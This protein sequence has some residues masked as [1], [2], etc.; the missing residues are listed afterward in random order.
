MPLY[1]TICNISTFNNDTLKGST[2]T[3]A[4]YKR[5][6]SIASVSATWR[7]YKLRER[8]FEIKLK[9]LEDK[10]QTENLVHSETKDFLIKKIQSTNEETLKWERKYDQDVGALDSKI[11][12]LTT[13]RT[14]LLDKLNTLRARRQ[15]EI[16][17][18]INKTEQEMPQHAL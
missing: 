12:T 13:E 5:K 3:D 2:A 14:A 15:K 7:A 10:L 16:D 18:E 9:E 17:E 4:K 1:N 6:E 8:Q 11:N